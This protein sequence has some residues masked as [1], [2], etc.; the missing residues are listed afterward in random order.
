MKRTLGT[1]ALTGAIALLAAGCGGSKHAGTTTSTTTSTTSASTAAKTTTTTAAPA[2]SGG[3][4]SKKAYDTEM[5][6]LGKVLGT[7][8]ATLPQAA[9]AKQGATAVKKAQADIRNLGK[10]L[11]AIKPPAAVKA[12]HAQLVKAV[13]ELADQ[14]TPILGKLEKG[15]FKVMGQLA[16]LTSFDDITKAVDKIEAAGY[17]ISG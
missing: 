15:N 16:N 2:S 12:D 13:Y 10:K 8:L 11:Q 7:S 17:P 4:L 9:N 3:T 14:L 1:L 5:A 6:T